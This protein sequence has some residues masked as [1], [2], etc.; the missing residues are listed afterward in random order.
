MRHAF[1]LIFLCLLGASPALGQ[2]RFDPRG[3]TLAVAPLDHRNVTSA[4]PPEETLMRTALCLADD[5]PV[6]VTAY[7]KS[8]PGSAGETQ[9]YADF[10]DEISGCM[11]RMDMSMVGNMERARGTLSMRFEQSALRGALAESI[12][13]ELKI[14]LLPATFNLGEDGMFVAER[15]HGDRSSNVG[16]AFALG[17]A[18][19]VMGLNP[20]RIE[21]LLATAPGSGAERGIIVDMAPSFSQCVM[22]GQELKLSP[23]TLRNQ[24]AEVVYYAHFSD[25]TSEG[26]E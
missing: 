16:R 20:D 9:T 18:G 8:V 22:E 17:F 25:M 7:L 21:P 12:M 19:C 6:K 11:P 15:F 13:R 26:S 3:F 2:D 4:T 5:H 10:Q 14:R 23:P 1:T 24:I